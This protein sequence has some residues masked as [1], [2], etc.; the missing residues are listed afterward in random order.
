MHR[1]P[2]LA[3]AVMASTICSALPLFASTASA[4]GVATTRPLLVTTIDT[5][6]DGGYGLLARDATGDHVLVAESEASDVYAL[7]T[8]RDGSRVAYFQDLY[9]DA[10]DLSHERL[11]VRDT[12]L[13][14]TPGFVRV[15]SDL[16]PANGE[17]FDVVPA[18]SPDGSTVVWSR[19]DLNGTTPTVSTLRAGVA[20]GTASTVADGLFGAA[21]LD[22]STL[23]GTTESGVVTLPAAGGAETAVAGLTASDTGFA[24][25]PDAAHVSWTRDTSDATTSMA[26]VHVA[27]L[28]VAAGVATLT[29]DR[30]LASDVE[31]SGPTWAPDGSHVLFVITD[32]GGAGSVWSAPQDGSTPRTSAVVPTGD[33]WSIGYAVSDAVAPGSATL[34]PA[35]LAA[36]SATLRWALPADGDVYA[37]ELSRTAPS[38]KTITVK[39]PATSYVDTGLA[40]GTTYTYSAVVVDKA[41]NRS[42]AVTRQLTTLAATATVPDPTSTRYYLNPSFRVYF[43]TGTY[44][45]QY[46]AN[47]SGG[48]TTWLDHAAGSSQVFSTAKAGSSY[49]LLMTRYDGF[50]NSTAP[51][52]IGTAVVPYDQTRASYS[53]SYVTQTLNERYLG[54]A[55][56]LKTAGSAARLVVNGNRL[57]VVGEKCTSCGVMDVY[58]DGVR[59]AGIDTHDTQRRSRFVLYTRNL[60]AGVNHTVVIKAR[61]TAGRPN[62]VLDAFGVRH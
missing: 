35:T 46:R 38:P 11:V 25:S 12:T 48:L 22:A 51:T 60:T 4:E 1:R 29:A 56:I 31:A 42:P 32:A 58:V 55:T 34:L 26:E 45:V 41:G 27:D 49:G 28:A 19:I 21:F 20:S 30:T 40:L 13:F 44:T 59:V 54:N 17:V 52:G 39:A 53:G 16:T 7:A 8:S 47:G 6:G 33:I 57:Q 36:T 3:V 50:G 61:G 62:V 18:L 2:L 24:V 14:G 15:V 5:D 37:V 10:G 9:D 23:I 43:P